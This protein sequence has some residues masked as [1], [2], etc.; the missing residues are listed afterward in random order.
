VWDLDHRGATFDDSEPRGSKI[1]GFRW[2]F[3]EYRRG[4]ERCPWPARTSTLNYDDAR[5]FDMSQELEHHCPSCGEEKTF[6][7]SAS[8]HLHLGLKTKWGCPDCDY[9][10]VL[11]D[12]DIDSSAKA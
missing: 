7:R 4:S 8:T 12:G 11:I 1:R 9:R 6:Y 2:Q 5:F 3:Q 10:F